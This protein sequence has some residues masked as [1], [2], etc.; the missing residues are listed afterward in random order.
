MHFEAGIIRLRDKINPIHHISII[1]S[2]GKL[3]KRP[4]TIPLP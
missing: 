4:T 2:I 3:N 1:Y